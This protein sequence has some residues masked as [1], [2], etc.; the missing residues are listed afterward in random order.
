MTGF[1][2][3]KLCIGFN[4]G[5]SNAAAKAILVALASFYDE[6][7]G[8]VIYA[9]AEE[10]CVMASCSRNTVF[11]AVTWLKEV[12][13]IESRRTWGKNEYKLNVPLI[14]SG[15]LDSIKS[16]T[17]ESHRTKFHTVEGDDVSSKSTTYVSSKSTTQL[18]SKST[19]ELSTN[20][21]TN[22]SS[23]ST[24][25]INTNTK[26]IQKQI[27]SDPFAPISEQLQTLRQPV[28]D[29]FLD[30]PVHVLTA[31]ELVRLCKTERI[32]VGSSSALVEIC[33]KGNLT[34]LAAK[35]LI[36]DFKRTTYPV[37]YLIGM[38]RNFV[39]ESGQTNGSQPGWM[40]DD[41]K[42]PF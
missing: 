2:L 30:D 31:P 4:F 42:I 6:R 16:N 5:Q 25:W 26:Q 28:S 3:T 10:L 39:N 21:D 7:T 34:V 24:T 38:F 33:K 23:K 1:D 11:K 22:V 17:K 20:F 41:W 18:S 27:D 36:G 15:H 32:S 19:T 12:G 35:R 37:S 40:A 29:S 13:L 14:E 8:G 9:Q